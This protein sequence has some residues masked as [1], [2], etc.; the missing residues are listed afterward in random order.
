[1][2]PAFEKI[3]PHDFFSSKAERIKV[4]DSR[5]HWKDGEKW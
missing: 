2:S 3:C 1:M 4:F 5:K